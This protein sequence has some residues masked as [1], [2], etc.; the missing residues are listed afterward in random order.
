MQKLPLGTQAFDK[1]RNADAVYIDKTEHIYNLINNGSVYFFSRPRRF[2]K[3]LLISTFKEL[4]NANKDLFKDLYIYNKWNW[5]N[6][7]PVIH[8]Q[9]VDQLEVSLDK[10]LDDIATRENITLEKTTTRLISVKF[11]ELIEKL[12]ES[13]S[14]QVVV[15]IDEYDKPLIDNLNDEEIY[16]RIKKIL[17][18]FYLRLYSAR[19]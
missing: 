13:T 10:F 18:N 16:K 15:L 1:L 7:Y 5:S 4:F 9:T 3:S 19:A 11:S 12:H 17:H 2:G 8:Y 14:Q 6:K